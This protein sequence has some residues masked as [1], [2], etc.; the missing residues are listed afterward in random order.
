MERIL[1]DNY[2]DKYVRAT[3]VYAKD[4][5]GVLQAY[6]DADFTVAINS[7]DLYEIGVKGVIVVIGDEELF[8]VAV[9]AA[10]EGLPTALRIVTTVSS[11][12]T[13]VDVVAVDP[14]D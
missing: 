14:E 13:L 4:N 6:A 8:P 9:V 10:A 7:A 1:N 11:A 3:K 5:K 12:V 2:E